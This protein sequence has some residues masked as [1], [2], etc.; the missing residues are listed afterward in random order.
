MY[1][2]EGEFILQHEYERRNIRIIDF[3]FTYEVKF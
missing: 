3:F 1:L 2:C